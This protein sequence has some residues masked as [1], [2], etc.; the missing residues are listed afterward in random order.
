[1]RFFQLLSLR[2]FRKVPFGCFNISTT[3]KPPEH[4][5]INYI[6]VHKRL[7]D[8]EEN[9][10]TSD[11]GDIGCIPMVIKTKLSH[12]LDRMSCIPFAQFHLHVHDKDKS[13]FTIG[14]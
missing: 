3:V 1:M 11:P 2:P 10:W 8:L 7:R 4:A 14:D 9:R 12:A 5:V 13:T 6:R